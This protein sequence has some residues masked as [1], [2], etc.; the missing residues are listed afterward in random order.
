MNCLKGNRQLAGDGLFVF[1]KTVRI[2]IDDSLSFVERDANWF[3]WGSDLSLM[4]FNC[5][6]NDQEDGE[7]SAL[8]AFAG[9]TEL[10]GA[11]KRAG[12]E[13]KITLTNWKDGLR[14]TR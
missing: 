13:F 8:T 7:E 14:S 5:F 3:P 11:L 1:Q 6:I 12:S 9:D 10:E 2:V 4:L